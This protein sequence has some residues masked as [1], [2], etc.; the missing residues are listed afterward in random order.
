[1]NRIVQNK[2]KKRHCGQCK[3][4]WFDR[5]R[6]GCSIDSEAAT[7]PTGHEVEA[8]MWSMKCTEFKEKTLLIEE[9]RWVL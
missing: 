4:F 8:D 3:H 5:M 2:G 7:Y 6:H 9:K 1:M